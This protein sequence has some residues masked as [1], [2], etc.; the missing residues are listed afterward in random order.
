M[1]WPY[2]VGAP[3]RSAPA[4]IDRWL[5]PGARRLEHHS[6]VV[7][8][9]PR[10]ALAAIGAVRLRDVPIVGA[11]FTLRGIPH[12][13]DATLLEFFGTSPFLILEEEPGRE[14]VFGVVGPFW[15]LRRGR[16]PPR[17]PATPAEFRAALAEGR[18][19][20]VGNFRVEPTEDGSRLWTETWGWVPGSVEATAFTAYWMLVG[21]FSAWI[22][23][24]LLRAG[25]RGAEAGRVIR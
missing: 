15:Q 25:R 21:P 24:L 8:A 6:I 22:R 20:A 12:R 9:E 10:A 7:G 1:L 23:R 14:L 4:C 13:A 3:P 19:A 18:M 11:L 2:G 16:L 5:P 17:I